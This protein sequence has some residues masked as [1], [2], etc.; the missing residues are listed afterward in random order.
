MTSFVMRIFR[1]EMHLPSA[2]KGMTDPGCNANAHALHPLRYDRV[3]L[4]VQATSYFAASEVDV[5]FFDEGT[6]LA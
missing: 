5:Q 4:E 1:S 2:E 3:P 6:R